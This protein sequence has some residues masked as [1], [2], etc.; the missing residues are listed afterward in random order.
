VFMND[1]LHFK[2]QECRVLRRE[3]EV[4]LDELKR[5]QDIIS[6]L[7]IEKNNK[8]IDMYDPNNPEVLHKRISRRSNENSN[9]IWN[10][11]IFI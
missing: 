8:S 7:K 4:A 9:I 11:K 3:K 2:F 10:K 6:R 1:L 5:A